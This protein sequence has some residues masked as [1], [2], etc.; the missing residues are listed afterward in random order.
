MKVITVP[1]GNNVL[2]EKEMTDL[3]L[4]I[5]LKLISYCQSALLWLTERRY[6]IVE[7]QLDE[8]EKLK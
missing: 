5:I 8:I 4:R 1:N 6:A 7:Q 3:K 2:L